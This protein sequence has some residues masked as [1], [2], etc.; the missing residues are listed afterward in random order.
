[1]G[2]TLPPAAALSPQKKTLSLYFPDY[3]VLREERHFNPLIKQF[4]PLIWFVRSLVP[5]P[6]LWLQNFMK[7][8]ISLTRCAAYSMYYN[9]W[10]AP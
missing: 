7:P 9:R 6:K 8:F 10:V 2:L 3:W 1:M 4:T 5:L